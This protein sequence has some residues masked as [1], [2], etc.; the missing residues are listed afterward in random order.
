MPRFSHRVIPAIACLA[1]AGAGLVPLVACDADGSAAR[2]RATGAD[3]TRGIIDQAPARTATGVAALLSDENIFALLDTAYADML[4][5]DR[6]GQSRASGAAVAALAARAIPQNALA[7]S[8]VRATAERLRIAKVLPDHAVIRDHAAAM[9]RLDT[10]PTGAAFDR[11]YI[12]RVIETRTA[13]IDNIDEA[14][15]HGPRPDAVKRFLTELR[16]TL[17][18]DRD[19]AQQIRSRLG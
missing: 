11:A 19:Q 14:L 8:G 10:A 7:R 17:Q 15:G 5:E 16:S 6:V 1:A 2:S 18:A 3:T 12:D 9:A 13:L 4:A